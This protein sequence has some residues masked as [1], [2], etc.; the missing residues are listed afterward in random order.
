M[1]LLITLG[2]VAWGAY[3]FLKANTK[4]GAET[5]RAHIFLGGIL[6]G[7]SAQEANDAASIDVVALPTEVLHSA[8]A[9][10]KGQYGGKQVS[11]ISDAYRYGMR[12][13]LPAWYRAFFVSSAAPPPDLVKQAKVA[14]KTDLVSTASLD[15]DTYYATFTREVKRLDGKAA[16]EFHWIDIIEH[17]GSKRAHADRF[18]P[19]ALAAMVHRQGPPL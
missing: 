9:H 8:I 18:D 3:A 11:M 15:Y 17:E 2:V 7:A 16:G 5:V 10:L 6:A 13:K 12:P 4:R 14:P 1:E 19:L